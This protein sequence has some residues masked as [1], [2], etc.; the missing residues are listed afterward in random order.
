MNDQIH[1]IGVFDDIRL[2][3]E[4][5]RVNSSCVLIQLSLMNK[6]YI[7]IF[8]QWDWKGVFEGINNEMEEMFVFCFVLLFFLFFH[9]FL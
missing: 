2:T 1:W 7:F 8:V 5:K 9:S 3:K 4:G 6:Q